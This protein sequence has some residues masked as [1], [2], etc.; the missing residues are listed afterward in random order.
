[1]PTENENNNTGVV[2]QKE[3]SKMLISKE[4]GDLYVNCFQNIRN[5]GKAK[6]GEKYE[7]RPQTLVENIRFREAEGLLEKAT[8]LAT[9]NLIHREGAYSRKKIESDSQ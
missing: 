3:K 7:E 2:T 8:D 9:F 6:L 1:M 4:I 5:P